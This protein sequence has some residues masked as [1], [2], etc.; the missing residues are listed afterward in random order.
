MKEFLFLGLDL[1]SNFCLS[2]ID[3]IKSPARESTKPMIVYIKFVSIF[4]FVKVT[5]TGSRITK[6]EMA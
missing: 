1:N 3:S 6:I 4:L 2:A 5:V